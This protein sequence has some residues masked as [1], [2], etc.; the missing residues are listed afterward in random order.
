MDETETIDIDPD[1]VGDGYPVEELN[2]VIDTSQFRFQLALE[3][4]P[5]GDNWSGEDPRYFANAIGQNVGS[6]VTKFEEGDSI[7]A[8][9]EIGDALNYLLFLQSAIELRS[10]DD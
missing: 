5:K 8:M 6:A 9:D 10:A 7:G 2:T 4:H 3:H 1:I